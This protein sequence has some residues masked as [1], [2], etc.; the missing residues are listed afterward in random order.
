ML[1]DFVHRLLKQTVEAEFCI[2]KGVLGFRRAHLPDYRQMAPA[3]VMTLLQ[4]AAMR[5][6]N[7]VFPPV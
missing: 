1:S 2:I 3:Q 4:V 6:I 7:A 5:S